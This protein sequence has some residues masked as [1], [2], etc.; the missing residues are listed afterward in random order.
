M[1]C[2]NTKYGFSLKGSEAA[3]FISFNFQCVDLEV[4]HIYTYM[5][6]YN[7]IGV[8]VAAQDTTN[9]LGDFTQCCILHRCCILQLVELLFLPF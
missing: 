4:L 5:Y 8:V 3:S 1:H 7:Y 2:D 6:M 9:A